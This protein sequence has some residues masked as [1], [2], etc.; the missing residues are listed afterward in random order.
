MLSC[1]LCCSFRTVRLLCLILLQQSSLK[2]PLFSQMLCLGGLGLCFWMSVEVSCPAGRQSNHCLTAKAPPCC[3]EARPV[4]AGSCCSAAF[5][6]MG[7]ALQ[8][9]LSVVVVAS[10][11]AGCISSGRVSRSG[12][13][14]SVM[15]DAPPPRS[16]SGT[17]STVS[18]WNRRFVCLTALFQTLCPCNPL[19]WP[20]AQVPFSL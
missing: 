16:A 9:S 6:T 19:G 15:V 3:C 11:M 12:R 10:A 20:T 7:Y 1:E 14:A 2:N 4:A 8:Q 5:S 17:V 13:V 18:I